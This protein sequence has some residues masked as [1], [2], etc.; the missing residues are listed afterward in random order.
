MVTFHLRCAPLTVSLASAGTAVNGD[1]LVEG[2]A[3][4]RES[5]AITVS[6]YSSADGICRGVSALTSRALRL[7]SEPVTL[8]DGDLVVLGASSTLR[9]KACPPPASPRRK[10]SYS[11]YCLACIPPGSPSLGVI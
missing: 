9:V 3:H 7:C 6:G 2:G 1:D 11:K 5:C 4:C 8:A 10:I